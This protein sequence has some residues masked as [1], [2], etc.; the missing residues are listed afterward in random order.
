MKKIL[1]FLSIAVAAF[2][3]HSCEDV[4]APYEYPTAADKETS[5]REIL[6]AINGYFAFEEFSETL[7]E[8][9]A[10]NT[11]G[12]FT[13]EA[14]SQYK[15]AVASSYEDI[16]G[17]GE[18][19]N[20]K[21]ES[22]LL[23]KP[24]DF[25]NVKGAY[26]EF[27]YILCYATESQIPTHYQLRVSKDFVKGGDIKAANWET[28]S[29][30]LVKASNFNTWYNSGK[31]AIPST[32]MGE[33]RVTIALF[34]KSTN[35]AATWEVR[36][37]AI[38]EGEGNSSDDKEDDK[39]EGV[40]KLIY[41]EDF[42]SG[43]GA[44]TIDNKNMPSDLSFIWQHTT[45]NNSGYAKASAFKV[46]AY[47]AEGWLVSPSIDLT[48][49]TSATLS[50]AHTGKFFGTPSKEALVM[51]KE[52]GGN[53]T[54]QTIN[55]WFANTDYTFVD[56]SI[57]LNAY[58]GKKIQVAF[59]YKST[60][61]NAGTWEVKNFAI[62][63]VTTD[64]SGD[65]DKPVTP[66]TPVTGENLVVNGDFE[67]WTDGKPNH[68]KTASTAGNATLSQSNV[69]RSGSYSVS[70]AGA[71]ANKRIG[72]EEMVLKAGT[73]KMQFYVRAATPEGGS[74]R[75]GYATFNADGSI[76]SSG[77]KYGDYVNDLLNSEWREVTHEFTLDKEQKIALVIMNSK[78]PGKDVL[79]DDFSLTT[80][81]GGVVSGGDTGGTETPD[82][83][84]PPVTEGYFSESFASG[85]GA[86]TIENET[87]SGELEYVWKHGTY[88]ED[89]FAKASAFKGSA[90]AAESW[91]VSPSID[92]TSA[93]AATLSFAHTGKYFSNMT[94]EVRVMAKAEGGEWAALTIDSWFTNNDYTFV[95]VSIN[96]NA[97]AGK[98]IQIAFVY[99]STASAAGTWEVKNVV[100][101]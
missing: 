16:D 88:N 81:N 59:V 79:I 57:N 84:E 48:K 37:L 101:K 52:E 51:V 28:I 90:C 40:E 34:Y 43:L 31:I 93:T 6:T 36:N 98:K 5:N 49:A 67:D 54:E 23:S 66:D 75:P 11:L 87:L 2:A 97:Y 38:A 89:A 73:Y 7:G 80:A 33:S 8:F 50:F 12:D 19:D 91:L 78:N 63:G 74:V 70:V 41:K 58:A 29:L 42:A 17:D 25:S 1:S 47:A 69:A 94:E 61:E 95:D 45:Y 85:L 68:W 83:P 3:L 32:F 39:E 55:N 22:W 4:P 60:A 44:F 56:V 99:K 71:S 100:I 92:L 9:Y 10:A 86:F 14:S 62:N 46:Q 18:E 82:T 26:V 96:L 27:E 30:P 65:T 20:N 72:Y 53:W 35:K 76:N 77:Y 15:C 21:A 24:C 64:D 13:W